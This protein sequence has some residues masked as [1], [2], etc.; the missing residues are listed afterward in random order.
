MVLHADLWRARRCRKLC[1][2]EVRIAKGSFHGGTLL[3]DDTSVSSSEIIVQAVAGATKRRLVKNWVA[4]VIRSDALLDEVRDFR[5]SALRHRD[6]PTDAD[7]HSR[8]SA[9]KNLRH[10]AS[11]PA[12][13]R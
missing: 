1:V 5:G 7:L 8:R 12:S 6:R 4:S 3:V 9:G 2:V 10:R 13:S 11:R